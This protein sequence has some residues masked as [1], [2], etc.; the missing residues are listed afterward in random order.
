MAARARD[1]AIAHPVADPGFAIVVNRLDAT[2]SEADAIAIQETDGRKNE[3]A[4]RAR[5]VDLKGSIGRTQLRRLVRIAEL[6]AKDHPDLKG[7]FPMP[8][9]DMPNKSFLL[10]AR[11]LLATA[12]PNKDLFVSLGIGDRFIEDLTQATDQL[13]AATATSHTGRTNHIAANADLPLLVRACIRDIDVV[14]TFYR[15]AFPKDSDLLAAWLSA[16]NVVGPFKHQAVV[17]PAPVPPA[18]S[19]EKAA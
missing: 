9:A 13:E 19:G 6:A 4:F 12:I 11:G 10:A 3:S 17:T 2:V 7:Q 5:R 18:G 14:E 8:A 15:A 1:F 16:R